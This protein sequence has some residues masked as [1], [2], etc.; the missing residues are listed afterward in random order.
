MSPSSLS[1]P[2][3]SVAPSPAPFSIQ[4]ET[5][6]DT[7]A[8]ER[9]VERVFGDVMRTRAAWHLRQGVPHDPALAH[10]ARVEGEIVGTVSCTPI[11][12][13]G[14]KVVM[15]GPLA[16]DPARRTAGMGS[17]LMHHVLAAARA[18][19]EKRTGGLVLLVGDPPYY[20]RFGFT[21]VPHRQITFTHPVDYARVMALEL[22]PGR[23]AEVRGVARKAV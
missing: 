10:V 1:S 15:L 16:V 7:P 2:S 9:L 14:S 18:L 11:R 20:A 23:L 8:V 5:P 3:S 17:A 12:V 4:P 13:G 19:P 6:A 22:V 21:P